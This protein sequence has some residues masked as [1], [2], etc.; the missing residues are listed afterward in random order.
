MTDTL[1]SPD[2]WKAFV[3]MLIPFDD[4]MEQRMLTDLSR[5]FGVPVDFVRDRMR[6][7]LKAFM[8]ERRREVHEPDDT[9]H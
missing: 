3:T 9:L 8:A 7:Y 2:F 1:Y 5:R 6:D 4:A